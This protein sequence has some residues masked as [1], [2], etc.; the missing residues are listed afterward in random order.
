M[1]IITNEFEFEQVSEEY[2]LKLL[3]STKS[4]KATLSNH[5]PGKILKENADILHSKM[6]N[7]INTNLINNTCPD[8]IKYADLIPVHK[9]G[10]RTNPV[11]YRP[12]SK[13][14]TTTITTTPP[15]TTAAAT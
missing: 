1:P 13:L 5:I 10:V 3:K 4:G 9:D 14:T 11:K 8:T 6:T 12:V 15:T 7:L 2:I